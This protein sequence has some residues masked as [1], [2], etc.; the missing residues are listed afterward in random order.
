MWSIWVQHPKTRA[1]F[2]VVAPVAVISIIIFY[3]LSYWN[4]NTF[5]CHLCHQHGPGVHMAGKLKNW[6]YS[7]SRRRSRGGPHMVVPETATFRAS[8]DRD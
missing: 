1:D 6:R 5:C 2:D 3:G 4:Y 7:D 8:V